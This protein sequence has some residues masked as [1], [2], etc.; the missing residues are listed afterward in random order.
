MDYEKLKIK[1]KILL[2]EK[3][4]SESKMCEE[5][6]VTREGYSKS[7]RVK[8]IN[9]N[10]LQSVANY[11]GVPL[12]HLLGDTKTNISTE[13]EDYKTKYFQAVEFIAQKLGSMPN[14]KFV[15]NV[16]ICFSLFFCGLLTYLLT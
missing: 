10:T 8:S 2:A 13:N 12:W 5:I 16:A 15:S 7:F 6:G 1:I 3:G 9:V 14:F 11:L 4:T